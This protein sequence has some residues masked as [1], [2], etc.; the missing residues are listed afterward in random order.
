MQW[1]LCYLYL[2]L[3]FFS[4]NTKAISYV[5]LSKI[6]NINRFSS[7]LNWI[8]LCF[9]GIF[10]SGMCFVFWNK[11]CDILGTVKIS[12]GIYLIPVV[13]I[14]LATIFL[15]EKLTL[16]GGIG[17]LLTIIGLWVSG[18]ESKS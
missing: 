10:T 11:V 16:M 9:L 17:S 6:E 4:D 2:F 3:E 13:T 5:E 14:I 1:F 8:L 18:D 15:H 7:I 12:I